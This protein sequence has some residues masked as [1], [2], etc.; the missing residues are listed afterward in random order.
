MAGMANPTNGRT[1]MVDGKTVYD[2]RAERGW[3]REE[4]V[5]Q[6][7]ETSGVRLTASGLRQIEAKSACDCLISTVL[8]LAEAFH[9]PLEE[10]LTVEE[11]AS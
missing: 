11:V 2:L 8:G 3:S 6:V 5:F 10:L 4:C 9:V 7:R 1:Q